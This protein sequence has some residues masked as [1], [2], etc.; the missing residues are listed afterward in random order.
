[1]LILLFI[2]N[3]NSSEFQRRRSP[4]SI[5]LYRVEC[6]LQY[7]IGRKMCVFGIS[8]ELINH[9]YLKFYFTFSCKSIFDVS[10]KKCFSITSH[11]WKP[12]LKTIKVSLWLLISNFL[13]IFSWFEWNS[14]EI[15]ICVVLIGPCYKVSGIEFPFRLRLQTPT[16][17][18]LFGNTFNKT[19][20]L[21]FIYYIKTLK[22]PLKSNKSRPSFKMKNLLTAYDIRNA[23][24]TTLLLHL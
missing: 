10:L 13:P 7:V 15:W 11:V 2:I 9:I 8:S 5:N 23:K 1:M 21:V 6:A 24:T 22:S 17:V 12:L 4:R 18:K 19:V 16:D 14:I 20:R 3:Q